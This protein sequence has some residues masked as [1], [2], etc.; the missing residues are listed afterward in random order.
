MLVVVHGGKNKITGASLTKYAVPNTW[1]LRQ[2]SRLMVFTYMGV[3]A[4]LD[5]TDIHSPQIN[6]GFVL[7]ELRSNL[8]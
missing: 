4:G 1:G 6:S 8:L 2:V 3:Y 7:T 5:H